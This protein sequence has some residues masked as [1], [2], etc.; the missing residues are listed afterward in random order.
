MRPRF[1]QDQALNPQLLC[2]V[3]TH[4]WVPFGSF[5]QLP[6]HL[7]WALLPRAT[8]LCEGRRFSTP[9]WLGWLWKVM[10]APEFPVGS[11][12]L[13]QQHCSSASPRPVPASPPSRGGSWASH[14]PPAHK[15]QRLR[16]FPRRHDLRQLRQWP[17]SCQALC[18]SG[19]VLDQWET[20]ATHIGK[21]HTQS[22]INPLTQIIEE[23]RS[24][25]SIKPVLLVL[26]LRAWMLWLILLY[27]HSTS[28]YSW[29]CLL[30][31]F[32]N[33]QRHLASNGKVLSRQLSRSSTQLVFLWVSLPGILLYF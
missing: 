33:V 13:L 12:L 18:M 31:V 10:P 9:S 22:H 11:A 19:T 6:T 26:I 17:T 8:S 7:S 4:I 30:C 5:P 3:A 14:H 27:V 24:R 16:A 29:E 15:S 20:N 28:P 2:M 23:S 32:R 21:L 1:L 25:V